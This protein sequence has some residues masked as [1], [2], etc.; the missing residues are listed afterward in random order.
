MKKLAISLLFLS[1]A[2]THV[3]RAEDSL[4]KD[5]PK[6]TAWTRVQAEDFWDT[7][8]QRF[9]FTKHQ[10]GRVINGDPVNTEIY[11]LSEKY[12]YKTIANMDCYSQPLDATQNYRLVMVS[13]AG[14]SA[15][16]SLPSDWQMSSGNFEQSQNAAVPLY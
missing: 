7:V 1:S 13:G 10:M 8:D 5:Y 2:C 3:E 6:T 4:A 9:E 14:G 16:V 11:Q 12:C 15:K